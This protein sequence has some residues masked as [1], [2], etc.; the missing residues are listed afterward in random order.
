M[1]V[2]IPCEVLFFVLMVVG[3][4]MWPSSINTVLMGTVTLLLWYIPVVSASAEEDITFR[5]V[6][7]SVRINLLDFGADFYF[8]G[9]IL[10]IKQKCLATLL[11][12]RGCTRYVTSESMCKHIS[13][14]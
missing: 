14:V 10:S 5:T 8:P 12:S 1:D 11:R 7:H 3:G 2:R 13:L 6:W 9:V 4:C